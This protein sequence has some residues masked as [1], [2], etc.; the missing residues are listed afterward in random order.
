[1]KNLFLAAI[2]L[3]SASAAQAQ[4]KSSKSKTKNSTAYAKMNADKQQKLN[5]L[6]LDA[7][8]ADSL[9][10]LEDSL[11]Y[12]QLDSTRNA[13]KM[14]KT[15]EIDSINNETF[16]SLAGTRE[17][18][19]VQERNWQVAYKSAKISP[20]KWQQVSYINTDYTNAVSDVKADEMMSAE[21]KAAKLEAI[22]KDKQMKLKN[23]VGKSASK[24]LAK[25]EKIAMENTS[26]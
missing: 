5:N 13:W 19:R 10:I 4:T 22:E 2:I 8:E 15:N 21:D 16:T 9:R 17:S 20:A 11:S 3:V 25:A 26:M 12:A 6:R 18:Q 23:L 24:R 7:L 1:M 14:Q